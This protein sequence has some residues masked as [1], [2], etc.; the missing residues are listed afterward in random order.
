MATEKDFHE[1][2]EKCKDPVYFY[3]NYFTVNGKPPPKL[4]DYQKGIMRELIKM[5]KEKGIAII[6]TRSRSKP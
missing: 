3:E 4:N 6:H 1:E 2:I 5:R